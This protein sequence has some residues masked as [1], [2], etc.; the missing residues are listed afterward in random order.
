MDNLQF[1]CIVYEN[2]YILTQNGY[3]NI[4]DL[5]NDYINNNNL[6]NHK[7]SK[8]KIWNGNDW[9]LVKIKKNTEDYNTIYKILLSD[10]CELLCSKDVYL[11]I[12]KINEYNLSQEINNIKIVDLKI[13]DSLNTY[14]FPLID[15]DCNENILYPYT[16]GYYS[17]CMNKLD[18]HE[19]ELRFE[20][21]LIY[22]NLIDNKQKIQKKIEICGK[23]SFDK[24]KNSLTGLLKVDMEKNIQAPIN[25][26]IENKLLWLGGLIDNNGFI[27]KLCDAKYLNISVLSKKFAMEIKFLFN[28]L[29]IN[30]KICLKNNI[31]KFKTDSGEID[32]IIKHHWI[33]TLNADETNK[34]F[35]KSEFDLKTYYLNYDKNIYSIDQ[36]INRFIY[37]KKINQIKLK[38]SSYIIENINSYVING[39]L[40]SN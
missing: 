27:T 38:K 36:D 22:I 26:S 1:Y 13:N 32:E 17:G 31:R 37:I 9:I 28:T 5:Y 24:T 34:I 11:N 33:I 23:Y 20:S 14:N 18:G 35:L 16:H 10:G 30:P 8:F 6:N 15:G 4:E 7:Q 21:N 29:G 25:G 40:I 3:Y 19:D 39:V 12:I 2:S